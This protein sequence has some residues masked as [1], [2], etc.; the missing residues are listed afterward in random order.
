MNGNR[1]VLSFDTKV[2][3]QLRR[4]GLG[5]LEVPCLVKHRVVA[6]FDNTRGSVEVHYVLVGGGITQEDTGEIVMVEFTPSRA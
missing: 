6:R 4:R 5:R 1:L 3:E 2:I